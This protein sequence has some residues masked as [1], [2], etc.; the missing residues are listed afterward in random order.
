MWHRPAAAARRA[1]PARASPPPAR[2]RCCCCSTPRPRGPR[3]ARAPSR[4]SPPTGGRAPPRGRGARSAA[5]R[6]PPAALAPRPSDMRVPSPRRR[7]RGRTGAHPPWL[8]TLA[9]PPPRPQPL[10]HAGA[11]P[12]VCAR[13]AAACRP[14]GRASCRVRPGTAPALRLPPAPAPSRTPARRPP[15]TSPLPAPPSAGIWSQVKRAPKANRKRKTFEV[16]GP[17][18]PGAMPV[19]E[20]ARQVFQYF[21]SYNYK[22]GHGGLFWWLITFCYFRV[23]CLARG[24]SARA[25]SCSP[26]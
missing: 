22:V 14:C 6:P 16:P 8:V 25:S 21:K 7:R 26:A 23:E 10:R 13:W 19:D 3:R 20:R 24:V 1:A 12:D 15:F 17:G 9:S 2:S 11:V 4:A 5:R 18:V